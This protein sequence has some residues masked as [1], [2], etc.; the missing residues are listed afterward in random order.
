[1]DLIQLTENL[2]L[3]P[4]AIIGI[5]IVELFTHSKTGEHV[6]WVFNIM[7]DDGILV[8][9]RSFDTREEL[10]DFKNMVLL[11]L[12]TPEDKDDV[13]PPFW[14]DPNVPQVPQ[15]TPYVPPTVQQFAPVYG[16]GTAYP[17]NKFSLVPTITQSPTPTI[18]TKGGTINMV[19][20]LD[21]SNVMASI[22]SV[23]NELAK[24]DEETRNA[25]PKV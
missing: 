10:I 23:R 15:Y 17:I 1:M 2:I 13:E 16:A 19:A 4:D 9:V 8:E 22:E 12:L 11:Q 6:R 21:T 3:R 24:L 18:T 14:M 7:L 5:R 20:K 25:L